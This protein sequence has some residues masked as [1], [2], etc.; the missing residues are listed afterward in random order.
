MDK[1]VIS[2]NDGES[3]FYNFHIS[4]LD[5]LFCG[6]QKCYPRHSFG[7]Y[8]RPHFL[9]VFIHSG[10]GMFRTQDR[11][12]KLEKG[13]TFF[14]F[15]GAITYYEADCDDPWEYSWIAFGCTVGIKDVEQLLLRSS[16]SAQSPVHVAPREGE[17]QRLYRQIISYCR[18]ELPY[19]DIK[20]MSLFWDIIYQYTVTA[21]RIDSMPRLSSPL[22]DHISIAIEYIKCYYSSGISVQMIADHV[23]ISREHLCALFKRQYGVS[24]IRFLQS[25]RLQ[26]ASVLLLTTDYSIGKISEISGFSDYNYFTNQFKHNFGISP[27]HYRK[28]GVDSTPFLNYS[29]T[30]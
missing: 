18:G 15:P 26:S 19:K 10:K 14:L 5:L 16:V 27:S 7:P 24:P 23:G 9:M 21:N 20:I 3:Y 25:F 17:L 2:D 8:V 28:T 12:Y 11:V 1:V 13:S 29:I 6:T 30:G 22:S 4:H